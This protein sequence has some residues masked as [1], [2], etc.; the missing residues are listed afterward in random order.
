MK[1]IALSELLSDVAIVNRA[2]RLYSLFY[3]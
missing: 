2:R 3:M 1:N